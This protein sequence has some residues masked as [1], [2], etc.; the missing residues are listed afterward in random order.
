MPRLG[1]SPLGTV[2]EEPGGLVDIQYLYDVFG[3]SI[4]APRVEEK[5]VQ[6]A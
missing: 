5:E 1:S 2:V 3:D 6:Q 4:F